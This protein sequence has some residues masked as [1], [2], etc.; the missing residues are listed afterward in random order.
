MDGPLAGVTVIDAGTFLAAPY[1]A[2]VLAGFGAEVIKVERLEGDSLR[3]L[4]PVVKGVSAGFTSVNASKRT[5]AIDLGDDRGRAVLRHLIRGADVLVHNMRAGRDSRYGI[6]CE[7]CHDANPRLLHASVG[8][9]YPS[10]GDR[11]GYDILFQSESGLLDLTGEPDRPPSRIGAS[12][13]DHVSGL[14]LATGVL[15]ALRGPRDRATVRVSMLDV[16]VALLSDRISAFTVTGVTPGRM[17]GRTSVTTPLGP[18]ATADAYLVV[19]AFTDRAFV[20][21]AEILG[22]PVAG[23]PRFASQAGRLAHRDELEGLIESALRA[24]PADEW[25]ETLDAAGIPVAR[26]YTLA[27]AVERHRALSDT[28]LRPVRG[29]EPL[30]VVAAPVQL[31]GARPD[32]VELPGQIGADTRAVLQDAG[33]AE[34]E[35][36]E[37]LAAGVIAA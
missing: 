37:L 11:P 36:D 10:H 17:G 34:S 33:V 13:I 8:G 23:D 28:G 12:A 7:A 1:A 19:G 5:V 31:D 32:P 18:F 20:Q 14:W 30:E 4:P 24:R 3:T 21:L 25:V 15:A 27:E 22:P 29:A 16:A 6:D 9:F 2:S 26:V 35:I